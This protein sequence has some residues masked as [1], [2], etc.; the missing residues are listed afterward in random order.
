MC[1]RAQNLLGKNAVYAGEHRRYVGC[2]GAKKISLRE[3]QYM[4]G[5]TGEVLVVMRPKITVKRR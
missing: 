5:N 1:Q 4:Q 2:Q 3:M